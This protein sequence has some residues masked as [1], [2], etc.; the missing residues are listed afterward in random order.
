MSLR[1]GALRVRIPLFVQQTFIFW[2]VS[3]FLAG[4]IEGSF[5]S[6]YR[7]SAFD[8]PRHKRSNNYLLILQCLD[9]ETG[10]FQF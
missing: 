1:F 3:F 9:Y 10:R 2:S 4:L 7:R 8:F 6:L 5:H